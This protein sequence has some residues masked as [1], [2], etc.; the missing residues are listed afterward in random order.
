[1]TVE[2]PTSALQMKRGH[3][4]SLG[5]CAEPRCTRAGRYS[6]KILATYV[7]KDSGIPGK[8]YLCRPCAEAERERWSE[9]SGDCGSEGVE[10][11]GAVA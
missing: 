3:K 6:I 11:A 7:M 8:V 5:Q 1:M 9:L 10:R 2:H 4:G